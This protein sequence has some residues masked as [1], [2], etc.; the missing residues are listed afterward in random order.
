[1]TSKE[2]SGKGLDRAHPEASSVLALTPESL[3]RELRVSTSVVSGLET[4]TQ[5]TS[6]FFKFIH[7][8]KV[9]EF[10]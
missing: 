8:G 4:G 9:I 3:C 1:M 7:M 5:A 6:T 2:S 10:T